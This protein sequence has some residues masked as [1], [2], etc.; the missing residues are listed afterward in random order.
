MRQ[1]QPAGTDQRL[2]LLLRPHGGRLRL[3]RHA[4]RRHARVD[5]GWAALHLALRGAA[6]GRTRAPHRPAG[7][8]HPPAAGRQP[9]PRARHARTVDQERHDEPHLVVQGPRRG[10][11]QQP[12]PPVRLRDAGL[13]LDR[14]PGQLRRRARRPRRHA[15]RRLHPA[16][17]GS[18]QGAGLRH[19][20]PHDRL[21]QRLLRR[22]QPPLLGAGRR[23]PLGLRQHQRAALL[24]R[25]QPHAGLRGRRAAG[26]AQA[27][28]V[29]RAHGQRR[30]VHER[31]TRG[32]QSSPRWA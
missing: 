13:R 7:R 17:P 5:L 31:S 30:A 11:G 3:R 20:R 28:P 19:L 1:R 12:R 21:G 25:G 2:R 26:L 24:R 27:R 4:R 6:A 10:R 15:R 29:R 22:R 9:G 14:Q 8:L 32:S 18:R 16:R 23:P